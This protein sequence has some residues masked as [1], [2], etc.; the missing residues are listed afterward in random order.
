MPVAFRW[1]CAAGIFLLTFSAGDIQL[2]IMENALYKKRHLVAKNISIGIVGYG[3]VGKATSLFGCQNVK[4]LI[5]DV[6]EV[7]DF[8]GTNC[9]YCSDIAD[10]KNANLI[11]VSV[12][13]PMEENGR[14]HTGIVESVVEKL[15]EHVG[16]TPIIV[17]STVPVG[18]CKK[19]GVNF[20]PEFLTEKNWVNDFRETKNWVVGTYDP[21]NSDFKE[22]IRML[23][24]M[25]HK[26][27]RIHNPPVIH[28]TPSDEAEMCKDMKN[29]FLATK[30]SFFNELEEF[31]RLKGVSY[32]LTKEL[33]CLDERVCES[34][35]SVPGPDGKRGFGG[36]CFPKDMEAL[37]AEM[38][39]AGMTSYI[40]DAALRRNEAVDRPEQDWKED[41]GRAVL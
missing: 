40:I 1:L 27:E 28:F 14:C 23:F 32:D 17:R 3:Y 38:I 15:K 37:L 5:H 36:T 21:N 22:K 7:T 19:I 29:C 2:Y 31:C 26:N 34:H 13:T 11:F 12:P 33:V 4:V 35:T 30:V 8:V 20:M 18:F 24:R 10:L 39:D 25:A 16:D 41:K 9:V 6:R